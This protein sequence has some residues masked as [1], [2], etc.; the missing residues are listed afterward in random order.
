MQLWNGSSISSASQ[1]AVS[2]VVSEDAYVARMFAWFETVDRFMTEYGW[3]LTL[4]SPR[5]VHPEGPIPRNGSQWLGR[6]D[7]RKKHFATLVEI[8]AS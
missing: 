4:F 8:R 6:C 2:G 1:T 7:L 5:E 3:P